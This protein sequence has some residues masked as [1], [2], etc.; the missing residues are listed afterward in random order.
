VEN[1]RNPWENLCVRENLRGEC[2]KSMGK[3]VL[4][5]CGGECGVWWRMCEIHGKPLAFAWRMCQI[6]GKP[7]LHN[8]LKL[9]SI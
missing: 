1:V 2:A 3:P 5:C 8:I 7:P 9:T 6:H 4:W